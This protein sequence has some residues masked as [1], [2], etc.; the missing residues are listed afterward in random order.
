VEI[1]PD[2]YLGVDKMTKT[3][4]TVVIGAALEKVYTFAVDWRNF[5]RYL[6]YVHDIKPVNEKVIGV[7]AQYNL[8]VKFLGRMMTSDWECIEF[9]EKVGWTFSATLGGAK[10]SKQWR[11][12]SEDG[13]T[14]VTFTMFYKPSP[15]VIGNIIDVLLIRPQWRKIYKRAFAELKHLMEA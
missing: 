14:R 3:E 1:L 9:L 15:P 7:G 8:K 12:A 6:L 10:A 5:K 4:E 11:F 2:A 13:S